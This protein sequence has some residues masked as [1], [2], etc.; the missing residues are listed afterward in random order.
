M[1]K[2]LLIVI[3]AV[4][5]LTIGGIGGFWFKANNDANVKAETVKIGFMDI[6]ELTTQE[7]TTKEVVAVT[8]D[9]LK[10]FNISIPFTGSKLIFSCPVNIK[11]GFDF[12]QIKLDTNELTKTIKVRMPEVKILSCKVDNNGFQVWDEAN[13]IF[14]PVTMPDTN[15][16][17][18]EMKETAKKDAIEH[19][20][21]DKA[22]SNAETMLKG[23]IG[24]SFDLNEYKI[25][26]AY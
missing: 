5:G 4:V 18:E 19:G 2:I 12:G 21:Y 26:F 16:G 9:E 8:K 24:Q 13:C 22:K 7:S 10:P 17:M 15:K 3:G 11:A 20:I 1:K 6:G 25:E 23:F 14:N